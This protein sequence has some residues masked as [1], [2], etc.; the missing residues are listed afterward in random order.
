MQLHEKV[1]ILQDQGVHIPSPT[2]IDIGDEVNLANIKGPGTVLHLG[3]KLYGANLT[4]LAGAELGFEEPVTV[5]DCA[6]GRGVAQI[7]LWR[8]SVPVAG[9]G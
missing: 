7:H 3:T 8:V 6:V 4:I 2:S 5:E 9:F 1:A